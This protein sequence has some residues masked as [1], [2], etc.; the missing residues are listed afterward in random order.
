MLAIWCVKPINFFEVVTTFGKM[1]RRGE[2]GRPRSIAMKVQDGPDPA[3]NAWTVNLNL[4][5]DHATTV[6]DPGDPRVVLSL[7]LNK[8]VPGSPE[9]VATL[10]QVTLTFTADRRRARLAEW[11]RFYE[12]RAHKIELG[13]PRVGTCLQVERQ[14]PAG[15]ERGL[16]GTTYVLKAYP[17]PPPIHVPSSVMDYVLGFLDN[18]LQALWSPRVREYAGRRAPA[19]RRGVSDSDKDD[20][21]DKDSITEEVARAREK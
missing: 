2:L 9:S 11:H 12:G 5:Q 7:H 3:A 14:V 20:D 18:R 19:P 6:P 21:D 16:A 17:N 1:M 10:L 13:T 8:E 4:M 15:W